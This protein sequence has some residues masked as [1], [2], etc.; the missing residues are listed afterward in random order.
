[1][2]QSRFIAARRGTAF[3]FLL[4]CAMLIGGC[5][6]HSTSS[7]HRQRDVKPHVVSP[8]EVQRD[9]EAA[10]RK[11]IAKEDWRL[12][13][14]PLSH[15]ASDLPGLVCSV[16]YGARAQA[17]V[18][19]MPTE[20]AVE[21]WSPARGRV[22]A[23]AAKAEA[24]AAFDRI[25]ASAPGSPWRG[26]CIESKAWAKA[27][28]PEPWSLLVHVKAGPW[29]RLVETLRLGEPDPPDVAR[30]PHW[31]PHERDLFGMN[32]L[33]WAVVRRDRAH[34]EWMTQPPHDDRYDWCTLGGR[35]RGEIPPEWHQTEAFNLAV[36]RKDVELA[37]LLLPVR[38]E[39]K[40]PDG[41]VH[42]LFQD[43]WAQAL[44]TRQDTLVEPMLREMAVPDQ[45][46]QFA[47]AD[48]L[49]QAGYDVLAANVAFGPEKIDETLPLAAGA[50]A[51]SA[52]DTAFWLSETRRRGRQQDVDVAWDL[53]NREALWREPKAC[54]ETMALFAAAGA[55]VFP[56]SAILARAIAADIETARS[57]NLI[58]QRPLSKQE[59]Q[60]VV[61]VFRRAGGDAAAPVKGVCA[62]EPQR[63]FPI[64]CTPAEIA[65]RGTTAFRDVLPPPRSLAERY[66]YDAA[67]G[68]RSLEP[69]EGAM[70]DAMV[71]GC[72][73]ALD[74]PAVVRVTASC[75]ARHEQPVFVAKFVQ[76]TPDPNL[77]HVRISAPDR[78]RQL[79]VCRARKAQHIAFD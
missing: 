73:A 17:V 1:M 4:G 39:R 58:A 70:S 61:D 48:Q 32:A 24:V 59:A 41:Q 8:D 36:Q 56:G 46:R 9:P 47:L 13:T 78:D 14:L 51:C 53:F 72:L 45:K 5:G 28:P 22:K 27:T 11:A 10:A 75:L 57:A 40:C 77:C 52:K 33:S 25:V 18:T 26:L 42:P 20:I 71:K 54:G 69:M 43:A 23:Q 38:S 35:G 68:D 16:P 65:E 12:I 37:M 21:D 79:A 3:A 50:K 76:A 30:H 15:G 6:R 44:S 31:D 49:H 29:A 60:Q 2:G 55:R 7:N 67:H 34:V 62:P 63:R 19:Y 74:D 64:F 66:V